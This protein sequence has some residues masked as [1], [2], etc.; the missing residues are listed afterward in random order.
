[1]YEKIDLNNP[2]S[3]CSLLLWKYEILVKYIQ[4]KELVGEVLISFMILEP[5]CLKCSALF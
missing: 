1:M 4:K 3:I 5:S 2:M